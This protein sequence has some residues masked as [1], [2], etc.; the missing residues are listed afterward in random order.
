VDIGERVRP[1]R[2]GCSSITIKIDKRTDVKRH[3]YKMR[4]KGK[5]RLREE[6]RRWEGDERGKKEAQEKNAS[7]V[8]S[9]YMKSIL[10][11]SVKNP[12]SPSG[13]CPSI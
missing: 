2:N 3:T 13:L 7:R 6:G 9:R 4:T 1:F 11:D 12:I 5:R 10:F 8:T